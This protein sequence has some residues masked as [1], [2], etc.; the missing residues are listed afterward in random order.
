MLL[1]LAVSSLVN[2]Q[3]ES[4]TELL[5]AFDLNDIEQRINESMNGAVTNFILNCL[6]AHDGAFAESIS[7]SAFTSTM[8]GMRYDFQCYE[9]STL[10][11][12]ISTRI[13]NAY[14][15]ACSSCNFNL[16]DPCI[17]GK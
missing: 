13:S 11:P 5:C 16:T 15:H 4:Q 12:V 14:H 6:A 9:G 1:L 3:T 17:G 2:S 8:A 7:L 10:I